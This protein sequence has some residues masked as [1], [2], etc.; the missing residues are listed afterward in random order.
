VGDPVTAAPEEAQLTEPTDPARAAGALALLRQRD[1][2]RTYLAISASELGNAFHYI[3]LMWFALEAG[4][5]LGVIAVRL[6][7]SV[8]ALLFGLHDGLVADRFDRRKVMIG[9]DLVR[10]A[11]LVPVA[12]AGLGGE[13]PLWALVVAAFAMETAANYFEPA[14]GAFLPS[15]VARRNVQQA[16][17]L[18]R[19]T[20]S[21]LGVGGWALAAVLLAVLPLATFFAMNAVSFAVSA[22]LLVG[23]S[24]RPLAT[25]AHEARP[26]IR[27]GIRGA[28]AVADAR[29]RRRGDRG[30]R[31]RDGRDV[32][33]RSARARPVVAGGG[34]RRFA[35]VMVGY[36]LGAIAAGVVLARRPVRRKARASLLSWSLYLPAYLLLAV[37]ASLPVAAAG[38]FFAGVG[39]SAAVVLA[40]S[41]AQE[42]VRDEVLG[43]VTGLISLVHRGAHATGLVFVAPL[44]AVAETQAVF[45]V[46]A[47]LVPLIGLAGVAVAARAVAARSPQ[48][49]PGSPTEQVTTA[50]RTR[51]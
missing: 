17:A 28:P 31:D 5:P 26:R 12:V 21:A 15:V 39:Q 30:R 6:A 16:N 22:L 10:A 45:A 18:V 1:F 19:A 34:S 47:V 37:A 50:A 49:T 14:Y 29:R 13:L 20:D 27:E 35:L 40:Y 4:G 7:D 42:E 43:R 33:R 8:P 11:T 36:A 2:R 46:A 44:F 3:A 25:A 24:S 32:D 23:V 41:A 38:A 51:G 48:G 9:A